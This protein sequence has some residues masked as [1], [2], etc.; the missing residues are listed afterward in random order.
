MSN[1][2]SVSSLARDLDQSAVVE[3]PS[4]S[5]VVVTAGPGTGKT[6]TLLAR[7]QWLSDRDEIEPATELLVL[8]FSRAAVE[9][10]AQR[11]LEPGE[12]GAAPASVCSMM[13]PRSDSSM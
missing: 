13:T 6:R 9:T 4:S 2:G 12:H 5:R 8:S 1:E 7:T 3:A 11:G 10:V